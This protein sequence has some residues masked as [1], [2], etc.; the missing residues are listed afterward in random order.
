MESK[1]KDAYIEEAKWSGFGD[2]NCTDPASMF[3][4]MVA[5]P[6]DLIYKIEYYFFDKEKPIKSRAKSY[7]SKLWSF[8][9]HRK[10]G[11]CFTA[12]PP[13]E[14]IS[15]G[16]KKVKLVLFSH[17]KVF[18]HTPGM[19]ATNRQSTALSI[20]PGMYIEVDLEHE[21]F[22]MLDFG[23][24][25]CINDKDYNKDECTQNAHEKKVLQAVGCLTPFGP[26]KSQICGNNENRTIALKM[27]KET[28]EQ[29]QDNCNSPCMFITT[30]AVK[31][32]D[33]LQYSTYKKKKSGVMLIFFK[34]NIKVI[35]GHYLYSG[36]S[37]IAE[38]GGYVGLFLGV[39][40]NQITILVDKLF[41]WTD[42]SCNVRK[43]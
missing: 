16:I 3:E 42:Y 38:I 11:R 21:V 35:E 25:V 41:T 31:T 15:Y 32:S 14:L 39:S 33:Q 26:K 40:V 5:Q 19:F 22:S 12:M 27:Y 10:Y 18:F 7:G 1:L 4:H 37:L 13:N 9:D 29:Y 17:V 34:E 30:R 2:E 43:Y 36:L 20:I 28:F 8:S 23:G 6:Q 24:E